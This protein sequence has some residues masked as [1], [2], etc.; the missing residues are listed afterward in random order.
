M[1]L[2]KREISRYNNCETPLKFC[3]V[4]GHLMMKNKI[5]MATIIDLL[6][7]SFL[8]AFEIRRKAD[9]SFLFFLEIDITCYLEAPFSFNRINQR[10]HFLENITHLLLT[11]YSHEDE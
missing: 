11:F 10:I 3:N 9:F 4:A 1:P 6:N 7:I 5:C 2:Q 8:E